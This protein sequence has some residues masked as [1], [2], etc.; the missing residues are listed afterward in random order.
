MPIVRKAERVGPDARRT[1]NEAMV[2]YMDRLETETTH[3]SESIQ[4]E[5]DAQIGKHQAERSAIATRI[6]NESG[7]DAELRT[8]AEQRIKKLE[9]LKPRDTLS[10]MEFRDYQDM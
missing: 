7:G 4:A 3:E 10:E 8:N 1:L 9:S 5:Y 6:I 2:Q